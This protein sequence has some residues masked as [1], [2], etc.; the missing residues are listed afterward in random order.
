MWRESCVESPCTYSLF[1]FLNEHYLSRGQDW[2]RLFKRSVKQKTMGFPWF[3]PWLSPWNHESWGA[4]PLNPWTATSYDWQTWPPEE[5][6][7]GPKVPAS[8]RLP[9]VL[10]TM[11][12]DGDA[13]EKSALTWTKIPQSWCGT[14]ERPMILPLLES[15]Q[16]DILVFPKNGGTPKPNQIAS[17]KSTWML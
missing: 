5:P 4:C 17:G 11:A 15:N 12:H 3:C 8:L 10:I 16:V 1:G 9:T 13:S 2:L 14:V 6:P 7:L